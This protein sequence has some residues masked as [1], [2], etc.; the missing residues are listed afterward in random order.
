MSRDILKSNTCSVH[1]K[2]LELEGEPIYPIHSSYLVLTKSFLQVQPGTL[3]GRFTTVEGILT[4]IRDQLSSTIY[5]I[6]DTAHVGGDSLSAAEKEKWDRFFARLEKAINGEIKFVLTLVDPLANSYVQDL[7]EPDPDPQLT[8][9]E[10][11]RTDEEEDD[12]G[13]K[14][15]KTEGYEEDA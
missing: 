15:M 8:I 13:L 9:E 2:E 10:Y 4:E 1:S 3:G 6:E 11:T 12:L 5:D 7:C 14:D